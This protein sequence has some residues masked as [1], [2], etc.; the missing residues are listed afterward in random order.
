[1]H[2]EDGRS[3]G[4]DDDV[5]GDMAVAVVDGVGGEGQVFGGCFEG[6]GELFEGGHFCGWCLVCGGG[7]VLMG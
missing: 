7:V 5:A 4:G 3:V 2:V 6:A 1:M